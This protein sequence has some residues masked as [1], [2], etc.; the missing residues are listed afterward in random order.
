MSC[1]I[2]DKW[3]DLSVEDGCSDGPTVF[4]SLSLYMQLGHPFCRALG[5]VMWLALPH[6]T[7]ANVMHIETWEVLVP[8]CYFGTLMPREDTHN[9]WLDDERDRMPCL[10][11]NSLPTPRHMSETILTPAISLSPSWQKLHER[12]QPRSAEVV[13]IRKTLNWLTESRAK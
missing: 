6:E 8:S 3:H 12:A 5:L 4:S 9:S 13:Q 10:L 2:L 11:A 7:R 1:V